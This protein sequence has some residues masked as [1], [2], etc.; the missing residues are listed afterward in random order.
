MINNLHS[1]NGIKFERAFTAVQ[2]AMNSGVK[3]GFIRMVFF[4]CGLFSRT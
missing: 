4:F 3:I 2:Y 1:T